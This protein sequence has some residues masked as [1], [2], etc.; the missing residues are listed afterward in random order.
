MVLRNGTPLLFQG[1]PAMTNQLHIGQTVR[2]FGI[3]AKIDSFH[4]ITGDPILHPLWN[5]G[6]R[7]LADAAMCEPVA[8][9][10]AGALRHTDG[11]VCFG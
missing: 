8:E 11:L 6:D 3:L 7:W 10:P 2:N 1:V 9:T 5:D 4:E